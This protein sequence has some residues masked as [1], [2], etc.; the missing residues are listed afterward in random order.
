MKDLHEI[1][2]NKLEDISEI[3]E[4][5]KFLKFC[6]TGNLHRFGCINQ[7][8]I[9]AQKPD[10]ILAVPFKDWSDV[11]RIPGRNTGIH[12]Y[13]TEKFRVKAPCVFDI[14]D[15]KGKPFMGKIWKMEKE[16]AEYINQTFE[17]PDSS[18]EKTLEN[19][20]GTYVRGNI[21]VSNQYADEKIKNF[22]VDAAL[23]VILNRCGIKRSLSME[24]RQYFTSNR[25]NFEDFFNNT[26]PYIQNISHEIIRFISLGINEKR[27]LERKEHEYGN[28]TLD[29]GRNENNEY[30]GG[31]S[32]EVSGN[33]RS[34]D[35]DKREGNH[36][37]NRLSG[38]SSIEIPKGDISGTVFNHDDRREDATVRTE[39]SGGSERKHDGDRGTVFSEEPQEG[40]GRVY[41][42]GSGEK[43]GKTSGSGR[44]GERNSVSGTYSVNENDGQLSLFSSDTLKTNIVENAHNDEKEEIIE[45]E[46]KENLKKKYEE[47]PIEFA[48]VIAQHGTGVV[49]GKF[50]V[51]E[52]YEQGISASERA[53]KIKAEYGLGG[54][55][56]PLDGYGLYGYDTFQAKGIRF[57]WRT[58]DGEKEGFVSWNVFEQVIHD[59]IRTDKYLTAN[60]KEKWQ[61][62]KNGV[63]DTEPVEP[64]DESFNETNRDNDIEKNIEIGDIVKSVKGNYTVVKTNDENNEVKLVSNDGSE[65]VTH[66]F[67][68]IKNGKIL[69]GEMKSF[70]YD[71]QWS[72]NVGSDKERYANNIAAISLLKEIEKENRYA[73]EEEQKVLSLYIG[74]GGLSKAF[75]KNDDTWHTEY[76]K[77]KELLTD[78]E[79]KSA[80]SSVTDS[81]YTPKIVIEKIY[82]AIGN[83][84]G[85]QI[86]IKK[87]YTGD[88]MHYLCL[89]N[90]ETGRVYAT[91]FSDSGTGNMIKLRNLADKF[92]KMKENSKEKIDQIKA[93]I[94]TS[95]AEFQKEFIHADKLEELK[96]RQKEL[97]ELLLE[98]EN[99]E[100]ENVIKHKKI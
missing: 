89:C 87:S 34:E 82:E 27:Q 67:N 58:E 15:T 22:I 94:V 39:K 30:V 97:N 62:M 43:H 54:A 26:A 23:E 1:F 69:N 91:E 70:Y 28:G 42:G 98:T 83:L 36:S 17:S 4:Y 7:V 65:V 57:L 86:R 95:K 21:K 56:W 80:M 38:G 77:L 25:D 10:A 88:S 8:L 24:S 71:K 45:D 96:L 19:L 72:E 29:R 11:G 14:S 50:R 35:A 84:Y 40:T 55:G 76:K 99:K 2:K 61:I 68:Q 92:D 90:E 37:E 74:W 32:V 60:E 73:T 52:I 81:F 46:I 41:A 85:F 12:I 47:V 63:I 20:T 6:G 48:Q 33:R 44:S 5:E 66:S 59:L 9:Y 3:S 51:M 18:F 93:N 16:D 78:T 64:V 49:D 13:P 31:R 79:Y 100:E 75:D 53:K